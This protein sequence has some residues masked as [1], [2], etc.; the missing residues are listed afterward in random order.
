[1]LVVEV[2]EKPCFQALLEMEE[3]EALVVFLVV[4]AVVDQQEEKLVM[5]LDQV[6]MV[7]VAVLLL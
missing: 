2:E 6:E 7:A 1:V 3:M 4:V 5:L